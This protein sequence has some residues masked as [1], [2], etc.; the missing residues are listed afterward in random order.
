MEAGIPEHAAEVG[1]GFLTSLERDRLKQV[2]YSYPRQSIS[3]DLGSNMLR[4]WPTVA[5]RPC[6]R[7][8]KGFQLSIPNSRKELFFSAIF[9]LS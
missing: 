7:I 4:Y 9:F 2:G 5:A 3:P 8:R 1:Q 6:N